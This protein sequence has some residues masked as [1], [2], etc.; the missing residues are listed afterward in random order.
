MLKGE[1]NTRLQ[2]GS[3]IEAHGGTYPRKMFVPPPADL[4]PK[5]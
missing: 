5:F 2:D 1:A 3:H 4:K